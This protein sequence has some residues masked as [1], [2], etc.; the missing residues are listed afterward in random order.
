MLKIKTPS[1]EQRTVLGHFH[2]C[3][4]S[5]MVRQITLHNEK[6]SDTAIRCWPRGCHL[7]SYFIRPF[8]TRWDKQ[9]SWKSVVCKLTSTFFCHV[10]VLLHNPKCTSQQ[11]MAASL[12]RT[13]VVH[14]V[15]VSVG[16]RG[17]FILQMVASSYTTT[18]SSE[19]CQYSC[20]GSVVV[21]TLTQ[22][23]CSSFRTTS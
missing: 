23:Y 2:I 20:F 10:Y 1:L 14:P 11:A 3:L 7:F 18:A 16:G 9:S 21:V 6:H 19:R 5:P 12:A 17:V 4:C 22:M 15:V 13:R 8:H